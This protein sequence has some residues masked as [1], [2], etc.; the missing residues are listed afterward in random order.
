MKHDGENLRGSE[1]SQAAGYDENSE[2]K[3]FA[4]NPPEEAKETA[5]FELSKRVDNLMEKLLC[6]KKVLR[7]EMAPLIT[8]GQHS[9]STC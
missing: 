9:Q 4:C 1:E 6:L 5:P 2:T 7:G 8:G 3:N